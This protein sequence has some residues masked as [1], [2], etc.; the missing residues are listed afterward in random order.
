MF[1]SHCTPAWQLFSVFLRNLEGNDITWNALA[2]S[3]VQFPL[4]T[5]YPKIYKHICTSSVNSSTGG[6][7]ILCLYLQGSCMLSHQMKSINNRFPCGRF[8]T[9]KPATQHLQLAAFITISTVVL[10]NCTKFMIFQPQLHSEWK[11]IH[12]RIQSIREFF[13]SGCGWSC[14]YRKKQSSWYIR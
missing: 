14:W 12:D 1:L 10:L 8:A 11:P 7:T 3:S 5:K 6:T 2:I 9:S 13:Q 4:H